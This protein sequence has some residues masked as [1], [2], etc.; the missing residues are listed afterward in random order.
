ME[1]TKYYVRAYA[2]SDLGID[3]GNLDSLTTLTTA[4]P[5][6]VEEISPLM[7]A[8]LLPLVEYAGV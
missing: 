1:G 6:P 8:W 5:L 3:Y 4:S 7:A 2:V